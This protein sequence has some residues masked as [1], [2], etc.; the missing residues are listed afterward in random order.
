VFSRKRG[1]RQKFHGELVLEGS[2]EV[3][4]VTDIYTEEGPN[5][6]IPGTGHFN[7]IGNQGSHYIVTY[8]WDQWDDPANIT[9]VS[10]K[11]PGG[12]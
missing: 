1:D 5:H 3:F 10:V 4:K 6:T 9:F 11:C 7:V 12:K 2:N 8:L